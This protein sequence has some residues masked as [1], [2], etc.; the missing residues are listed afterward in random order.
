MAKYTITT[1]QG[2]KITIN[3]W[4]GNDKIFSAKVNTFL[5]Y[6]G[7]IFRRS[8]YI[9]NGYNQYCNCLNLHIVERYFN[10]YF[11]DFDMR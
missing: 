7:E 9:M 4:I 1:K 11:A 6:K 3:S 5:E 8:F 2:I 10:E